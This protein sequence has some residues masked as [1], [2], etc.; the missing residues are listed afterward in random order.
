MTTFLILFA[1]AFLFIYP[2]WRTLREDLLHLLYLHQHR[3]DP[4]PEVTKCD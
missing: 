3:N 1:L 2:G 4:E